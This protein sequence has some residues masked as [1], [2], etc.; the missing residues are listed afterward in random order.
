MGWNNPSIPWSELERKLSDQRRPGGPSLIADGG[1]SPAWSRKRHPY[2]PSEGLEAP[3]GPIVP[4]AELHA[5]STFSFLDGASTP[6]QLVEEA[7]RLGLSGLAVTDHD[8]FYGIVRFAEAAESFPELATVFGAELSLGLSEPQMGVADPEGEHLLVLARQEPGYHRLASAITAG[9]LA[10]GEKGRPTYALE[11]LAEQLGRR[12]GGAHRMP[13]GRGAAC[14]RRR[15]AGCRVARARP[16]G[17]AL[18][19]RQRRRGAVRPRASARPGGE[20]RAGG[21]RRTRPAAAPRDERGALRHP[22]RAPARLRARGG[23]G[24]AQP[25]RARRVAA[26]LRRPAPAQR[27]RDDAPLRALPGCGR[28]FGDAR[29]G[30]RLPAAER[31]PT[32]AAAGGAGR[33]HADELAARARVGGRR[34]ALPRPARPRARAARTRARRHR[35]EGLP[36]LLPHRLRPRARGAQPRHPVPGARLGRELGGLLRARHHRG[37][38]DLLR[39]AVRAVPLR[40]A[41]RGAR[42]RRGL[43]LRPARGDHPV[44]LR[45]VRPE[46]RRTGRERHQLPAEGRGARHGEGARLLHGAAGCVV[47]PGRALGRGGLHRRPRHPRAR[48]SSSPSSCSRSRGTSA[49]TRAAWCSPIGRSARCAPSSTPARRTAPCCSGTRTTARGWA[50]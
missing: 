36:R 32:P 26:R 8:G 13:Q 25:R 2:R 38:L 15:R 47:A 41:R 33:P 17:R 12:V 7:H 23:A 6:E 43:R 14:A 20:R 46:Q 31:A 29:R 1:D 37:R 34:E 45:Q 39:P 5:H 22:R 9:Q 44:R 40:P 49:S 16:A 48:S 18:R 3:A 42:H 11:E 4:Y 27:S 30:A 24:E 35:A 28:P 50:S 19:A 10:G 21:A